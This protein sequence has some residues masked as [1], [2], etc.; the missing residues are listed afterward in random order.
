MEHED[1]GVYTHNGV[2]IRY[3]Q[4]VPPRKPPGERTA[5]EYILVHLQVLTP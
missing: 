2:R 3:L 5:D 4:H 1:N